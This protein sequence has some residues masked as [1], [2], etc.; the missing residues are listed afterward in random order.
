MDSGLIPQRINKV[1]NTKFQFLTQ[2]ISRVENASGMKYPPYYVEPRLIVSTSPV[3]RGQFGIMF[4]RTIPIVLEDE[5]TI[6]VQITAPLIL[7]GRVGTI[8]AIL[9][10]EFLHYLHLIRKIIKMDV[11]SDEISPSLFEQSYV[12]LSRLIQEKIVFKNDPFLVRLLSR[13]FTSG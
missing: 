6:V 12:D 10:H 3:E 4:A 1:I 9:A 5:L 2:G 11:L 13:K 7:F 8:H